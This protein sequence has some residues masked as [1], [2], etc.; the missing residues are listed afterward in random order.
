MP[1]PETR[2]SDIVWS[3][4]SGA[5]K[6]SIGTILFHQTVGRLLGVNVTDMKCL[7]ILVLSGSATPK[8]MAKHTGLSSGATTAMIDRL[9][10]AGLVERKPHPRDRRGTLLC[11]TGYAKRKLPL[12]FASMATA[13]ETLVS[14]YSRPELAVLASFFEKTEV[15]WEQERDK[16]QRLR[17]RLGARLSGTRG[18]HR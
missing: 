16:I 12:I 10:K 18:T 15:L 4:I 2:K 3:V 5:R 17:S 8:E 14:S 11:L 9:E 6:Y 7:D 1:K 13:M